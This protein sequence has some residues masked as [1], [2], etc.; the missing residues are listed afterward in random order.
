[1]FKKLFY[2]FAI[3]MALVINCAGSAFAANNQSDVQN[4]GVIIIKDDEFKNKFYF[5]K[6]KRIIQNKKNRYT[7]TAGDEIQSK[8]N[9]YC[10]EKGIS[11]NLLPNVNNII[12]FT[13][14]NNLDRLVCL[15]VKKTGL[16]K[17]VREDGIESVGN[18]YIFVPKLYVYVQIK[19]IAYIYDKNQLIGTSEFEKVN[20]SSEKM[21]KISD[22]TISYETLEQGASGQ[23]FS[24][25]IRHIRREIKNLF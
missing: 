5:D 9:D 24:G 11:N 13:K 6:A 25:C 10:L 1:M 19:I 14:Q 22:G 12:E 17:E 16:E 2:V 8:Y 18:R 21:Y 15:T 23:A 20:L 4:V 3:A 7:I